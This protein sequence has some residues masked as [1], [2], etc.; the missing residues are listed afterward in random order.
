MID[1]VASP[2]PAKRS[3]RPRSWLDSNRFDSC[4]WS[5]F[6][7]GTFV[8][9]RKTSRIPSVKRILRRMSGARNA[10]TRDSITSGLAPALVGGLGLCLLFGPCRLSGGGLVV[11]ARRFLV[12][13]RLGAALGAD[14][15]LRLR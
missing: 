5:T 2:P 9:A 14:L 12:R 8:S 1:A 11:G 13:R 3:S 7:T 6:G 4:A 15:R 10:W